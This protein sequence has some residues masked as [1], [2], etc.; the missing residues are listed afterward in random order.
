MKFIYIVSWGNPTIV[1]VGVSD[2]PSERIKAIVNQL[3][4]KIEHGCA[5]YI[6]SLQR[7]PY[8]I[9]KQCHA[10]LSQYRIGG[11][12]PDKKYKRETFQCDF[13]KAKTILENILLNHEATS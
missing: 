6:S 7:K 8:F 5:F 1:K 12:G 2:N 13:S 4:V 10:A 3:G 11:V 9:E